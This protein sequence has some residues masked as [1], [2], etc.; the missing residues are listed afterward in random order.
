MSL[1]LKSR[2]DTRDAKVERPTVRGAKFLEL[3]RVAFPV[4][5]LAT[6]SAPTES[7]AAR[8]AAR[9]LVGVVDE[10]RVP[11]VAARLENLMKLDREERE[12]ADVVRDRKNG[13]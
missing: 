13:R 7:M 1:R 4:S 8:R 12:L 11:S 5:V 6:S 2:E 9:V 3:S 10:T